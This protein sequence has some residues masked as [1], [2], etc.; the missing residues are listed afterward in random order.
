M[1]DSKDRLPY[2]QVVACLAHVFLTNETGKIALVLPHT[3][4][5]LLE[6]LLF[7]CSCS[8]MYVGI[9]R[10]AIDIFNHENFGCFCDFAI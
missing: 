3:C 9:A 5:S 10:V 7:C 1:Q 6:N 2:S 8:T 4:A